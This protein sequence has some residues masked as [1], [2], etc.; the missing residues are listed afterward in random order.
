MSHTL[1]FNFDTG[2][3]FAA[4][5]TTGGIRVGMNGICAIEFPPG[6]AM[7]EEANTLT[8]ATVEAF[9]DGQIESGCID[10]RAFA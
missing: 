1:N 2:T 6:H 9:I 7:F 8:P 10:I 3:F 4:H 5:T